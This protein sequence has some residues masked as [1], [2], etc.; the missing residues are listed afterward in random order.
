[1]I[2]LGELATG[3]RV[4]V[5]GGYTACGAEMAARISARVQ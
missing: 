4:A 5:G 3:A 2:G 1:M